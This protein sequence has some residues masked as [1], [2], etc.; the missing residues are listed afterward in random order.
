MIYY[1]S[2][3]PKVTQNRA[4]VFTDTDRIPR[5]ETGGMVGTGPK[6]T[7]DTRVANNFRAIA[8]DH[9]RDIHQRSPDTFGT[10]NVLLNASAYPVLMKPINSVEGANTSLSTTAMRTGKYNYFTGK[11]SNGFPISQTDSFGNDNAAR[12]SYDAPGSIT[13]R[14]GNNITSQNYEAKG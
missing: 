8:S 9:L 14:V 4:V 2:G 11:Y 3:V 13:F 12:S 7:P 10:T 1:I 6:Q 5:G